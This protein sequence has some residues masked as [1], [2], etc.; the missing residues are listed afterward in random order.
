MDTRLGSRTEKDGADKI[1]NYVD[2]TT[3]LNLGLWFLFAGATAL[4][5]LRIW[6]KMTRR[7]GLWYDDYILITSWVGAKML[8]T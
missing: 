8:P 5:A 2:P 6:M 1:T 7:H 4:L 3:Q